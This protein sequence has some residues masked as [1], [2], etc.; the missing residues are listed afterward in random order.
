MGRLDGRVALV[1]GGNTGIG[2]ATCLAL[3]DAGADVAVNYVAREEEARSLTEAVQG[4]GRRALAARADVSQETAVRSM[5]ERVVAELGRLDILVNNAGVLKVQPVAEMTA[6]DFDHMIAVHLR[7]TFLCCKYASAHMVARG[8]G[9]IIN[10][11]SQL[12]Y[13]GREQFT[14]YCAAKGGVLAFT[15]AFAR[16]MAPH[17]IRVN[18]IAP[19]LIDTGF[20]PMPEERKRA[21]AAALPLKR[22]GRVEDVAP[23][24][25]FLASDEASFYCGMT[26]SMN[27]GELMW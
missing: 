23:T 5:I 25:V 24:V 7:G 13:V 26:L 10:V 16:E 6:E 20:D 2:R 11:G 4:R 8:R 9:I 17:G 22:L 12:A 3:A 19:G 27:G 18:A 15:R 1:T 14:H 21:F